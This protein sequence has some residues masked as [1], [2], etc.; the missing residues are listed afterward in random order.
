MSTAKRAVRSLVI[1]WIAATFVIS[2][3]C[4]ANAQLVNPGFEDGGGSLTGWTEFNNPVGNVFASDETPHAGSWVAATSGSSDSTANY[5]GVMQGLS[6]APGEI[7]TVSAWVR[8]NTGS[9]LEGTNSLVMKIE[10][11]REFGASYETAGFISDSG[12]T[13][14]E[15]GSTPDEWTQHSLQAWAPA[16]TVEARA[17]FVF[18]QNNYDTGQ[19]LI[20]DVTFTTGEDA[21][22]QSPEFAWSLA[23][24]DEFDVDGLPD[25]NNWGYDVGIGNP[26]GWGNNEQ[27]YYTDSR[28]ENARVEDGTLIIEARQEEY[29]GRAYT[30]ARLLTKDK[31]SFHYGL[32]EIHAKL[33]STQGIWPAHWMMG[34]NVDEVGW[35]A[36]GE[37]DIMEFLGHDPT[38]VYQTVHWGAWPSNQNTG[39]SFEGP[40]FS[41]DFHTFAIHWKPEEIDWYVDDEMVFRAATTGMGDIFT[42]PFFLIL[43]TAVG[44]NWPGYPDE[45][46]V[47]PQY[48]II[49]YVRYYVEADPGDNDQD[50]DV[51]SDD[52]DALESCFSGSDVPWSNPA[53]R[54]FDADDDGDVDCDDLGSF[55][56]EWT[57]PPATVP[58]SPLCSK[59]YRQIGRRHTSVGS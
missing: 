2:V 5:S 11:Y 18:I 37:V 35:A 50:G 46:T 39:S 20:D 56:E 13:V 9:T 33:P 24:H 40:D 52:L 3:A 54:F 34:T 14:L 41:Q 53:C 43:N 16:G 7:W 23:W 4:L 22:D 36:C 30:S 57:G 12:L 48:H 26:A 55:I 27:E 59:P 25:P 15:A 45:T 58:P 47:F 28:L 42:L 44:G 49:D 51:D 6:A 1:R 31:V 17:S 29:Q 10:F 21:D 32:I 8:H 19:A 38:T